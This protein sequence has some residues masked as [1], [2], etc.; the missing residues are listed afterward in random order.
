MLAKFLNAS[1]AKTGNVND[2][3]LLRLLMDI[4]ERQTSQESAL[5]E[6][7]HPVLKRIYA[8]RGVVTEDD[9]NLD[10][11]GLYPPS[12]LKNI[13]QASALLAQAIIAKENILVV[14]D[15]DADGATSSALFLLCLQSM[16]HQRV[17]FLVPNRFEFGY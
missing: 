7:V 8:G 6:S 9:L 12:L 17:G 11:A 13:D 14:G 15:F 16:G 1:C 5:D 10:L 3:K 4:L 2:N